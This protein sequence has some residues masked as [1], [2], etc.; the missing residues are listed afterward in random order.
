LAHRLRKLGLE[1]KP[2]HSL[3]VY[4]EDGTLIGD[5]NADPFVDNR[6]IIELKA[7]KALADEHVTTSS[8]SWK[9]LLPPVSQVGFREPRSSDS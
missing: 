7:A 4:D 1:V 3:R 9:S 8:A 2:Q 6:L 5:S